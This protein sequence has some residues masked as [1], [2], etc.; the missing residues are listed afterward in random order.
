MRIGIIG[1]G[2]IGSAVARHWAE[3]GHQL[4]VS[5]KHQENAERLASELGGHAMVGTP[6]QAAK[7]GEVVLLTIPLGEVPKLSDKLRGFLKGKIVIDTCNPYPER[8]GE[9]ANEVLRSGKGTGIWTAKQ[10]PGARVVRG[11]SSVHAETVESQSHRTADPVGVPIAS[12][13]KN[14]LQIVGKLIRDAGFEPIIVGGL[15]DAKRFDPGTQTYGSDLGAR[16][17]R[18]QLGVGVGMEQKK[19]A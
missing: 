16:E 18:E 12:D 8:D 15:E 1:S 19:A 2:N 10:I 6:E 17:L 7:K 13:D 11:F 4:I 14:A 5:A 3:A 9:A